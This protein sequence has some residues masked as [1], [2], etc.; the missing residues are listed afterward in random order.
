LPEI[1][2]RRLLVVASYQG[3][4]NECYNQINEVFTSAHTLQKYH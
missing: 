1:A 2:L 3:R 4:L